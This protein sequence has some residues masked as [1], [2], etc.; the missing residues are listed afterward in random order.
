MMRTV[1][2]LLCLSVTAVGQDAKLVAVEKLT[3]TQKTELAA[4]QK[5]V[6]EAQAELNTVKAKIAAQHNFGQESYMEWSRW[7]V[8]QD[9]FI[10]QYGQHHILIQPATWT[11][12]R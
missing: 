12:W 9:D 10:L 5:K 4:A 8:I 6:D 3:D 2:L 11:G 7:Y 1:L